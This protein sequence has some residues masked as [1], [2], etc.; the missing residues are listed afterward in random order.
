MRCRPA[1]NGAPHAPTHNKLPKK[2]MASMLSL[3]ELDQ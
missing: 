2:T 1:K 3:P